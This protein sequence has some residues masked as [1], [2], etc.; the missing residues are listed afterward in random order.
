[1]IAT[2]L[3][4]GIVALTSLTSKIP[5]MKT[6]IYGDEAIFSYLE[7]IG[8]SALTVGVAIGLVIGLLGILFQFSNTRRRRA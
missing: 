5:A 2:A 8:I 6:V 7:P 1:M 3:G 4:G